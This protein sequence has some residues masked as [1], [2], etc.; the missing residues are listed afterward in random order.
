MRHLEL[1]IVPWVGALTMEAIKPGANA[2]LGHFLVPKC[3]H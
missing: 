3:Q 1:H 2:R